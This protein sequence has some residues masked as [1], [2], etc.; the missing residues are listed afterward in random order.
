M[1]GTSTPGPTGMIG[2]RGPMG[3]LGEPVC[4]AFLAGEPRKLI[5]TMSVSAPANGAFFAVGE[6]AT[7]S[8]KVTDQCGTPWSLDDLSAAR[9]ILSGPR[10]T[11]RN[12]TACKLLNCTTDRSVSGH[13]RIDLK[14][15]TYAE[16]SLANLSMQSDGTMLYQLG[17]V[18]DEAAGTYAAVLFLTAPSLVEQIVA[19]Q[20]LQI[21]TAVV[22]TQAPGPATDPKCAHCHKSPMNGHIYMH[23]SHPSAQN[24]IGSFAIDSLP[25]DTC[26]SCHN[27]DGYSPN[28]LVSKVHGLHRGEHQLAPG[29][30]HPE[31]GRGADSTMAEYTNVAFPAMPNQEKDCVACHA[32][33][34]WMQR[35]SRLACGGC[36]DNVFFDTG[37]L[38][39]P[40]KFSKTCATNDDC[41]GLGNYVT[42]DTGLA[43][44]VRASHAPMTD[45]A[46]CG[47][48]HGGDS[49]FS[50]IS[51]KHEILQRTQD[52]GL[53][54]Q[55]VDLSQG[56]G[57]S[58]TFNFG[59]TPVLKF[60]VTDKNGAAITDVLSNSAYSANLIVAGP[61]SSPEQ[62]YSGALNL[63][64]GAGAMTYDAVSGLYSYTFPGVL[65][66]NAV[67]PLN[68]PGAPTRPNPA[69][70]YT[71][72][73]YVNKS[74]T[75]NGSTFRNFGD[76]L[77]QFRIG[78]TDPAQPRNV[79]RDAAC[80][81]CHGNV[82]AH[83]GSRQNAEGC[84][85]CHTAGAMDRTLGANGAAC[86]SDAQCGGFAAGWEHCVDTKAPA[87]PDT[88]QVFNFDP[89]PSAAIDFR[90]L[91]HKVHY[92]RKLEGYAERNNVPNAGKLN[93]LA[94]NNTLD[95]LSEILMPQD[96]RSCKTC[97]ADTG[98]ACSAAAPCGYGQACVSNACVNQAWLE[99]SAVVCLSCHDTEAAY[100]HTQ[101]NTWTPPGPGSKPVET[102][103]VCHGLDSLFSVDKVHN[104]TDPY[105]PPYARD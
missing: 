83:G 99:A 42:C 15:P 79:I 103:E 11:L 78:T 94:F 63:K 39:P 104:I 56:T 81:N 9:L 93:I 92:G 50:P 28:A 32:D 20:T 43:V 17:A 38:N 3:D 57:A 22:G 44:C 84:H 55:N 91:I 34:R 59:D 68:N 37:T 96:A 47:L 64:T 12:K 74:T 6:S 18:T 70:T 62:L 24:A 73:L 21:G 48:C 45:D 88:C 49:S 25:I 77:V 26:V 30:A 51:K 8:M 67:A 71:A 4:P 14:A 89:T 1:S 101:I 58:G 60:S 90:V 19:E 54:I 13:H 36:H 72:W 53:Q 23:H 5:A 31:Y 7:L 80:N 61:T 97:H 16:P 29:V 2:P 35:P 100:G 27:S 75:V 95:D 102:C 76:S 65:P 85:T 87:G 41:I 98:T 52:P 40:R 86:G 82:Q 33:D 66:A 105:V 69:G 46:Q 10:G